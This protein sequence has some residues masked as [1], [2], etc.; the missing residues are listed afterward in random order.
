MHRFADADGFSSRI[1]Q[2]ELDDLVGSEAAC[3]ALA[4]NYAGPPL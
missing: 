3:R 4:E 2:A 1:Q